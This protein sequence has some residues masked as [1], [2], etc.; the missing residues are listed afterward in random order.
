[1]GTLATVASASY[2]LYQ[3]ASGEKEFTPGEV[4]AAILWAY[5]GSKANL[6]TRGFYKFLRKSGCLSNSFTA[7]TLVSTKDGFTRI[8]K[9]EIGDAVLSFNESTGKN[10]YQLV[11][12]VISSSKKTEIVNI[13]LES[14]SLIEATSE[15]LIFADGKWV[16]ARELH[17]GMA[18]KG[19]DGESTRILKVDRVVR[20]ETVYDLTVEKNHNFYITEEQILVHNISPCEKAAQALAKAVPKACT[21]KYVCDDFA[22]EFERLLLKK[23]VKGK[24][25]CVKST[26]APFVGSLRH[27]NVSKNNQH[28]AVQIGEMVFDSINPNGVPY[29]EWANDIGVNDGIGIRVS[30]EGMTGTYNGCI[31]GK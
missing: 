16:Q 13:K 6:L 27:G 26:R 19:A 10:E 4:G 22:V 29:A 2:E 9:I 21:G 11:L 5:A 30:S 20:D 28:F 1:M 31:P 8:D 23:G 7:D 17:E 15:H 12:A 14:G 3:F 25:L 24:R 18:L